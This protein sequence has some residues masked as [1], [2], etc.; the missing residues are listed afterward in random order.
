ML[1]STTTHI[2]TID[3]HACTSPSQFLEKPS[4]EII[5]AIQ[6]TCIMVAIVVVCVCVCAC[7]TRHDIV[8]VHVC[9]HQPAQPQNLG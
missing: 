4:I 2:E 8:H 5:K 9:M 6:T 7:E 1:Y 3:M